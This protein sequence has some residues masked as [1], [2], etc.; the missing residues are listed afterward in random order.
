M[1]RNGA[2]TGLRQAQSDIAVRIFFFFGACY[3]LFYHLH[4]LI[5]LNAKILLWPT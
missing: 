2:S 4:T 3:L 1:M 5:Y